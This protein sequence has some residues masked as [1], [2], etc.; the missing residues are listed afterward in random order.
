MFE[1]LKDSWRRLGDKRTS[2]RELI[3]TAEIL[4]KD[5]QHGKINESSKA[6]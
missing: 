1:F 6:N 5:F 2:T 3:E 4:L